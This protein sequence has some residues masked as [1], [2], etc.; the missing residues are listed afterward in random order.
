M[1]WP[2]FWVDFMFLLWLPPVSHVQ[3]LKQ[4]SRMH[5]EAFL[6]GKVCLFCYLFG[7]VMGMLAKIYH[8]N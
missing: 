1:N 8:N 4:S 7:I 3:N 6:F 2:N 5:P